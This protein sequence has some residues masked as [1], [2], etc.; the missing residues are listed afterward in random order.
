M[1]EENSKLLKRLAG[2]KGGRARF[3]KLSK[4]RRRE[5]AAM[6]AAARHRKT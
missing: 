3:E 2:S 6:G 1:N 5:I 4:K